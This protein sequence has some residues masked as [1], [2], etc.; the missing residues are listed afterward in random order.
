MTNTAG[1]TVVG[2]DWSEAS[3]AAVR[4]AAADAAR[5]HDRLHL[6]HGFSP[7]TGRYG[8]AMPALRALH[9]D[10]VDNA[11]DFLAAAVRVAR[12]AGGEELVVTTAMP[13]EHPAEALITASRGA[14]AL[15]LGASGDGVLAGT[16][17]VQVVSHAHCPVVVVRGQAAPAAGPVVVGVDGSPFSERALG[18]AFEEA[19]WRGAPLVA[20]H[21]WSDDDLLGGL[22]A[23]PMVVDWDAVRQDEELVLAERLA[24]WQERYP[25]VKVDRVVVR[26]RP[27]HQLIDWSRQAQLVVVGSRGRGGF[28]GLLLGST[29]QALIHRAECPV[30]VVRPDGEPR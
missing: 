19:C 13:E 23:F 16:K 10:L 17:A 9:D 20:V 12:G 14:R 28:S 21:A 2:V 7:F 1:V 11:K 30:M 18:A 29:S 22:G 24:G 27:R 5:H 26:D 6:V 15:V 3:T 8:I 4:W 25:D